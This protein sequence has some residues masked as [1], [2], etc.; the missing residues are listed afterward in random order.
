MTAKRRVRRR[1]VW[2]APGVAG[3][4]RDRAASSGMQVPTA[5]SDTRRRQP[6]TATPRHDARLRGTPASRYDFASDL[7]AGAGVVLS[8]GLLSLDFSPAA[9]A[10]L[11]ALDAL[12][13]DFF[14]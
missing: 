14:A 6:R 10:D 2:A 1:A 4:G 13:P 11:L 12:A 3:R 7:A 9:S 8:A 5:G